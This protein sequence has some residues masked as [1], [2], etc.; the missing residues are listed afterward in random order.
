MEVFN[1]WFLE[2]NRFSA[3]AGSLYFLLFVKNWKTNAGI[4]FLIL[5]ASFLAD[6]F[7]YF[8]IRLIYPNSFIIGNI[9]NMVNFFLVIWLFSRMINSKRKF[10]LAIGG[11]YLISA[12]VSFIYFFDFTESNTFIRSFQNTAIIL[13]SLITYFELLKSANLK[14]SKQPV[15]WISTGFFVFSSLVLLMGI[16]NN[17][18]IFDLKISN[19]GFA[20][21]FFINLVANASKNYIFFYAIVL[22]DKGFPE[23]ISSNTAS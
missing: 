19:E 17:Y 11:I 16:F 8:F 6:S 22:L 4:L 1:N 12:T 14:L 23:S 10:I 15:F 21:I 18:L 2:L 9:W 3:I 5:L 7:N 20:F 13:F